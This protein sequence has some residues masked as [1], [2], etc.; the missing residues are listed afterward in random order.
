MS[1]IPASQIDGLVAFTQERL[2][3]RKAFLNLMTDLSDFVAVREIWGARKKKFDGGLDW[4]FDII[5]DHNH[6]ARVT[7][8]YD[9]DGSNIADAQTN[10]K[11]GPRFVNASYTY[12]VREP[13]LQGSEIV[14]VDYV[15]T[16]YTRMMQSFY[17]L[18]EELL[19]GKPADSTDLL[20]PYGVE[21]WIT[22]SAT[23]GFNGGDPAG[24]ADGRAGISTTVQPRWANWTAG[25]SAVSKSDLIRKMKKAHQ[26]TK[27]RSPLS[28][29]EPKLGGMKNGIYGPSEVILDVQTILEQNNMSLGSE[30]ASQ[31]G[32]AVFKGTP[33]TYVPKLDDDTSEPI[34]MIDWNWMA[35]G[36]VD[37]WEE[38]LSKPMPV[39]GKSKV[40]R[41]DLD[42]SLNMVCTNLRRQ[43]VF[44]KV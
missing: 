22:K 14:I 5:T 35:V 8:L 34:Y 16:K 17:E 2:I 36:V 40:R 32:R 43:A 28:V 37:G 26:K 41:V 42:A 38:N 15:K 29:T 18:L 21:Y 10:G 19:W 4:R 13:E 31:D 39:H 6:S 7:A 27:F 25:Y 24:F 30:L 12:D 3:Q 23:E 11:V 20:T 33:L 1:G 44:T 9:T